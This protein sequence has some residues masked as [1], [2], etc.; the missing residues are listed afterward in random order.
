MLVV[1]SLHGSAVGELLLQLAY[2]QYVLFSSSPTLFVLPHFS[3]L[4]ND[5]GNNGPLQLAYFVFP[6]KVSVEVA[7]LSFYILCI[8]MN[9]NK[10]NV[11][12]TVL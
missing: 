11:K 8:H 6:M 7:P 1:P 5:T 2:E 12:E 3:P 4:P 9:M 10:T